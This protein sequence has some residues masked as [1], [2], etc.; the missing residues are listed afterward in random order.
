M[1]NKT[2]GYIRVSTQEQNTERQFIALEP[3][4]IPEGNLYVDQQSG[5]DFNRPAY[6]RMVRRLCRGDLLIVKS[7]DRLG[8][9]YCDIK[10]QWR[11]L[12]REKGADI[13]VLDMPLL[14]TTCYR[15]LLGTFISDLV[16][17][18]LSFTAQAERDCLR[19]RQA[20]GIAA[21][22]ARG[23]PFGKTPLLLPED[24]DTIFSR[25]RNRELS[26]DE[27]AALCGF[28][29]RTLYNKTKKLRLHDK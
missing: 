20:E 26:T 17:Q 9:N 16:L 19:Q 1:Q 10:E 29:R 5:R 22:K 13:R 8:R 6:R 25:W 21:A 14:D 12:T 24:F 3:F 15:D 2:F 27:A 7:I 18:I 28:S 23:T 4:N 11:L